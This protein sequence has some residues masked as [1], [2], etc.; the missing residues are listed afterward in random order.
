MCSKFLAAQF[1]T[2][3]SPPWANESCLRNLGF[4]RRRQGGRRRRRAALQAFACCAE[5]RVQLR[6]FGKNEAYSTAKTNAAACNSNTC[7]SMFA[8]AV[9]FACC[10]R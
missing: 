9:L 2:A 10:V 6:F 1:H 8:A 3:N 7:M 5:L 4:H